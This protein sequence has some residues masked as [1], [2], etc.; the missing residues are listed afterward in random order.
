MASDTKRSSAT[1]VGTVESSTEI[2]RGNFTCHETIIVEKPG[3]KYPNPVTVEWSGDNKSKGVALAVGDRVVLSCN[4]RGRKWEDPK[5]GAVKHFLSLSGWKIDEHDKS[6][7]DDG[8]RRNDP[9]APPMGGG[10]Y[11]A[12]DEEDPIPF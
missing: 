1:I 5:N 4:V 7:R 10:G 6:G 3:D 11:G 12:T 2:T 8:Q 9:P